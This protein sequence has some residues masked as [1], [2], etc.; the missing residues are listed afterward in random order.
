MEIVYVTGNAGKIKLAKM[1]YEDLDVQIIQENME[2]P[3]IQSDSCE[4]VAKF[5]AEYAANIWEN[6]L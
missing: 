5:S 6:Q 2:T 4:D 1:I 3:E